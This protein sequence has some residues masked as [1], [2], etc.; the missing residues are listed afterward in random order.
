MDIS[1]IPFLPQVAAFVE[2]S[3]YILFFI[4]TFTEGPL[5]MIGAG[6]L[7][8]LG[9]VAFWP[10]YL[11]MVAGD[12]TA[13]LV[14]YWVGYFTARRLIERFGHWIGV[15]PLVIEEMERLFKKYDL[16]ILTISKLTM[17]FGTGTATLLTAGMLGVSFVRYA[18][19]NLI[20]GFVWVFFLMMAGYFFGNIY[21]VIPWYFQIAFTLVVFVA[22]FFGLRAFSRRVAR[23]VH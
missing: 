11:A 9:Q 12:F 19:V 10:T 8:R 20:G 14:W 17:G 23:M 7:W 13:D 3:K 4:G 1:T 22:I 16:K 21:V 6:L 2:S 5:V 15:T 18:I